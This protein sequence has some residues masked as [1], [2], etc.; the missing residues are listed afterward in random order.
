MSAGAAAKH[1]L[2]NPRNHAPG[3]LSMTADALRAQKMLLR[4]SL[5]KKGEAIP[6]E[7]AQL[8]DRM[9]NQS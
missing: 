3:A 6:R 4:Q 9:R 5:S 8:T 7:L 1:I 2:A